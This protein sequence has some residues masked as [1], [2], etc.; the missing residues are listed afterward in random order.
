M[1]FLNR[2][3]ELSYLNTRFARNRAEIAVIYGRRRVGKSALLYHWSQD[4]LRFFFWSRRESEQLALARFA[5]ELQFARGQSGDEGVEF[6]DWGEAFQALGEW[7]KDERAVV[8]IDEF[9]YLVETSPGISTILQGAWDRQLQ[10]SQLYLALTGSVMSVMLREAVDA[11]APLYKRHT[12]PFQLNPLRIYDLLEFFPNLN[13]V[14][15][16]EMYAVFGGMPFN[17]LNVDSSA[18]LWQNLRREI[19]SPSGSLFAEPLVQLHEEIGTGD[20]RLFMRVLAAIAQGFHRRSD[21]ATRAALPDTRQVDHYLTTLIELGLVERREPLS[22]RQAKRSWGLYHIADPFYRFW[23]RWVLPRREVL[24]IGH[25]L[26]PT[27]DELRHNW[28]QFVAPIWEELARTHLFVASGR[29]FPFFVNEVGSWWSAQAQIDVVGVNRS[30][31]RV[32]LGEAKWLNTS[33]T[34]THLDRLVEQGQLWLDGDTGWDVH[35]ALFARSGFSD[36]L[37]DLAKT[38]REIHLFTPE[39]LMASGG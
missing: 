5:S 12:W 1:N 34:Q 31:R 29:N 2:K 35:Y 22:R 4:K 23:H 26:E 28:P 9:P 17:L 7:A 18:S 36:S 24:E 19:L 10:Y 16:V 14:E 11:S 21:I 27:Q 39:T 32:I 37:Q 15:I 25:G 30:E 33:M 38:E 6:S 13:P 8:V 20:P 3:R